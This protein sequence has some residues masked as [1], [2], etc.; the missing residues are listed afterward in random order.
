MKIEQVQLEKGINKEESNF[1]QINT[2]ET[3]VTERT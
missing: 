1:V 3:L 2:E